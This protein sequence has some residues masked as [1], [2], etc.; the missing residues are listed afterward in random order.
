MHTVHRPF[1]SA[2]ITQIMNLDSKSN[3]GKIKKGGEIEQ[4]GK[5]G[6]SFVDN[7]KEI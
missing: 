6:S 3:T 4:E 2:V 5:G 1:I 7:W